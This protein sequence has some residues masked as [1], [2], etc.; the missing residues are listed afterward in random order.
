[1]TRRA[2]FSLLAGGAAVA[3]DP[4]R[5]LWTTGKLISIPAPRRLKVFTIDTAL[6]SR[7]RARGL[8]AHGWDNGPHLKPGDR[9]TLAG[10]YE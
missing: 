4:E 8:A 9:F 2:L 6:H 7:L 3:A 1:M 5:L 10:V